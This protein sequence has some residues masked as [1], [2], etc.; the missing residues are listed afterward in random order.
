M[1]H[2]LAAG[3][4]LF[5]INFDGLSPYSVIY[6]IDLPGFARSSRNKF[7]KDKEKVEAQ[8]IE[9]LERWRRALNISKMNLVGHSFGGYLVTAYSIKYPDRVNHLI[10]ADP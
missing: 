6:A 2:G 4:A 8:Y 3:T 10:L 7:S 1:V 9:S 5:A